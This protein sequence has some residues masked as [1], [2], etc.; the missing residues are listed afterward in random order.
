MTTKNAS[1][2]AL[3][4]GK[5]AIIYGGGG[6]IGGA[7]ALAFAREGARVFLAGRSRGRLEEVGDLVRAAGGEVDTAVVD[8]LDAAA[9]DAHA[10]SVAA[11][12]RRIDVVLNALGL[13]HVQ[14]K[15]F[16]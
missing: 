11:R 8:A 10:E 2:S 7:A 15:S 12:A 13:Q 5:T 1:G 14:G 9:V 3:L 4:A 16:A 6:A